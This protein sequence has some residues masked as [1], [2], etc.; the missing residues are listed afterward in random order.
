VFEKR[1]NEFEELESKIGQRRYRTKS[2]IEKKAEKI[3][4]KAPDGLFDVVVGEED[5]NITLDYA[6]NKTVYKE[7]LKS[8]GKMILFTNNHEWS[9]AQII[10]VYR[11][12]AKIEDDFKRMKSPIMI[13]LEPVYHWTDQK[14]RV[15]VF[16]CVLALMLLLLLKRKLERGGIKLSLERMIEELSDVQLSVI[17]FYDVDKRLCLLL[18]LIHVIKET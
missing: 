8:F 11:G 6:V 10:R 9:T 17:K 14:I 16:C 4:A 5:G 15:H 1:K 18:L 3:Q 2:A 13:S 12:K 7:K